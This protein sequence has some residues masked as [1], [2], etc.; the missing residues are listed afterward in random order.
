MTSVK[1]QK[2]KNNKTSKFYR[3]SITLP[4]QIIDSLGWKQGDVLEVTLER[5]DT[6]VLRRLR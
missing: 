2:S 1:L 6:I 5:M 4:K 3:W